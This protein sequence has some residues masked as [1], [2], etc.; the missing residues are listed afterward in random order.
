MVSYWGC[1]WYSS[2]LKWE[3]WLDLQ[4]LDRHIHPDV[5]DILIS[6]PPSWAAASLLALP[7]LGSVLGADGIWSHTASTHLC[8]PFSLR[9]M[10]VPKDNSH[11]P[12]PHNHTLLPL[13]SPLARTRGSKGPAWL[14]VTSHALPYSPAALFKAEVRTPVPQIC[15][16]HNFTCVWTYLSACNRLSFISHG[17]HPIIPEDSL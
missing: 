1:C 11:Q 10:L 2:W 8:T 5:L 15:I 14:I 6:S 12:F 3:L 7:Y 16:F 9:T 4:P 17:W 13:Q